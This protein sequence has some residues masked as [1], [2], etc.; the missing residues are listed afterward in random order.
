MGCQGDSE[1]VPTSAWSVFK[2]ANWTAHQC[3]L[4]LRAQQ[5]W[6]SLDSCLQGRQRAGARTWAKDRNTGVEFHLL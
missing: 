6:G 3:G 4:V 1:T 2:R 5:M